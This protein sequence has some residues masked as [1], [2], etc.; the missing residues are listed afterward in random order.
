MAQLFDQVVEINGLPEHNR[1]PLAVLGSV[2]DF[3][4]QDR[5]HALEHEVY[6]V[7]P[8]S[9][10]GLENYHSDRRAIR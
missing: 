4:G 6:R 9:M 8:D 3:V 2:G 1:G 7:D 10:S 5:I